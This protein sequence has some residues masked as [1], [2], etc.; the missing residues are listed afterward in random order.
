MASVLPT[1]SVAEVTVVRPKPATNAGPGSPVN[2]DRV[3]HPDTIDVVPVTK[4]QD[5][6]TFRGKYI[7]WPGLFLF[8]ALT[9]GAIYLITA[10]SIN[11][12][13]A[14][15]D[16]VNGFDTRFKING[17]SGGGTT[18]VLPEAPGGS[19]NPQ[20]YPKRGCAQANYVSKNGQLYAEA[21]GK[22]VPFS[23]KGINWSGM[24]TGF[25]IPFGLWAN[26][27]NGTTLFEIA[28]FLAENRF[29]AVRLP[30]AINYIVNN[31]PPI[32]AIVNTYENAALNVT[33]YLSAITSI[34]Q[35]F[36]FRN[37]SVL[38]D[39]HTISGYENG[40]LP[41]QNAADQAKYLHAVDILTSTFC[42]AG[43]WNILG[44]DVKNEPYLGTWGDNS[45]NDFRLQ[46]QI[47]A[48]QMLKGCPNWLAFI[49]GISTGQQLTMDNENFYFYDW[50]G[51][52]LEGAANA[53]VQ[54]NVPHKV[55]YAP[56]YY[57]PAVYP[58]KYFLKGGYNNGE[59][60]VN[61]QEL[62]DAG[63]KN[64]IHMTAEHMFG[65]LRHSQD[66][67][68]VL[69]E[70]GGLYTQDAHPMKTTQRATKFLM[71]EMMQPGYAGGFLWSLN[72]ESGYQY[73][74]SD[75]RV[76]AQEGILQLSWTAV[77]EPFLHALTALDALPNLKTMP[78]L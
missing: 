16:R 54:L 68:V 62:D 35:A 9:A 49:E 46:A 58:Q 40:G 76:N 1:V 12:R 42:K 74:P 66:G 41:W 60:V 15:L 4:P 17:T 29:N 47:I 69:G 32:V 77:N 51:G 55:V 72:P 30:L 14:M 48:N 11:Q 53:P 71:Q 65:H 28:S 7:I 37:I 8:V 3:E 73:N 57:N 50:W 34:V 56:H 67:A 75:T 25:A 13:N 26:P 19:R 24:E 78:C 39:L 38:L 70:F 27:Q 52:G 10:N 2:G 64:R 20:V 43:F 61:Y 23:I 21:N 33:N 44:I 36:E 45:P 63:L 22:S 5:P 6:A 18:V 59:L 31:Q